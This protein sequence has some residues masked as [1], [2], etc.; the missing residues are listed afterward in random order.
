MEL[1]C[2]VLYKQAQLFLDPNNGQYHRA[3]ETKLN[4]P[5]FFVLLIFR[6]YTKPRKEKPIQQAL[7]TVPATHWGSWDNFLWIKEATADKQKPD[8]KP[9][10]KPKPKG[11][12]LDLQKSCLHSLIR[13]LKNVSMYFPA[14]NARHGVFSLPS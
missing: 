7:P 2:S 4:T 10:V 3:S 11:L 6:S 1:E 12:K 8:R 14:P 13:F 9:G 5:V